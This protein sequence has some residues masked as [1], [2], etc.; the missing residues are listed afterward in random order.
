M[1]GES[2]NT[3]AV[4]GVIAVVQTVFLVMLVA[5]L[6]ARRWYDRAR[7][8]AFTSG[9]AALAAPARD[10]LVADGS[11][12]NV[13]E[14]L[15]AL[16]AAAVV[17]YASFF[18]KSNVPEEKRDELAAAL[19]DAPWIRRAIAAAHSPRWWRRIE[20]ARAIALAGT[21]DDRA[22]VHRLFDDEQP[23]V[24]IAAV[25]CLPRVADAEL[26]GVVLD[27]YAAFPVMVRHYLE[28]TLIEMLGLVEPELVKRLRSDAAPASLAHWISLAAA[29]GSL[30]ALKIATE[31]A[32]HDSDIVRAAAA[33]ALR[34]VPTDMSVFTLGVLLADE[35]PRVRERAA[36]SLGVVGSPRALPLLQTSMRDAAWLVRRRSALALAQLG[37]GGRIAVR[38]LTKDADPYVANMATVVSGLSSGALLEL[39]EDWN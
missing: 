3:I 36:A 29:L 30:P 31:L 24:A 20:A 16:P 2:V 1:T 17:G 10:W 39:T 37:E 14:A 26:V 12:T 6:L 18:V 21:A 27:R 34:R 5:F 4:L 8:I 23:A 32:W 25:A 33:D 7:H 11:V 15:A 22:T 19:R 13:T 28:G 9:R 38:T 35:S